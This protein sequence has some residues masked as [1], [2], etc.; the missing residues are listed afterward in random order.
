MHIKSF[1]DWSALVLSFCFSSLSLVCS[2]WTLNCELHSV[3]Q[4][5]AAGPHDGMKHTKFRT[6]IKFFIDWKFILLQDRRKRLMSFS[7]AVFNTLIG[8]WFGD[9]PKLLSSV[10]IF[11][12]DD[13][14]ATTFHS[15]CSVLLPS[16]HQDQKIALDCPMALLDHPYS[17]PPS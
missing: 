14:P 1:F 5:W 10:N 8:M 17:P 3:V 9:N 7:N 15:L 4:Y 11:R 13:L 12:D 6:I 16:L 2:V